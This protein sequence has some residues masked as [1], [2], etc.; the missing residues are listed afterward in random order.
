MSHGHK[1]SLKGFRLGF[2]QAGVG[3]TRLFSIERIDLQGGNKAKLNLEL[4]DVMD[5]NAGVNTFTKENFSTGIDAS[6]VKRH[7]LC[8][9]NVSG[10][11][12]WGRR[13][14]PA[15][16]DSLTYAPV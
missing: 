9:A 5:M 14:K 6:D 2:F 8:S 13:S 11:V 16:V 4:K 15:A 12:G 10:G 7:L 1:P 3:L